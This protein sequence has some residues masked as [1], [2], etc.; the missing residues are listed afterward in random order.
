MLAFSSVW[1]RMYPEM[2]G[3]AILLP[4]DAVTIQIPEGSEFVFERNMDMRDSFHKK[5]SDQET[6]QR[7]EVHHS[8]AETTV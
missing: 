4:D 2:S 7:A 8:I 1:L 3:N 6:I 5:I